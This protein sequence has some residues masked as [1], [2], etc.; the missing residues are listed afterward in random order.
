MKSALV[1]IPGH[2]FSAIRMDEENA[3][4]YF[5]ETTMIGQSSFEDA[6]NYGAKEWE[7]IKPHLD[8]GEVGYTWVNL[9]EMREKGILP[10]PWN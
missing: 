8:A 4:Y 9:P 1:R 6:V 10:I 3:G 2:V 7:D 5:V